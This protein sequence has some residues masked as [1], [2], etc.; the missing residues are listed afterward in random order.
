MGWGGN[1]LSTGGLPGWFSNGG[2]FK[3]I[4]H[5]F[6]TCF[7]YALVFVRARVH[8]VWKTKDNFQGLVLIFHNVGPEDH[9]AWWQAPFPSEL[10][11]SLAPGAVVLKKSNLT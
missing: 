10:A 8:P 4:L 1:A 6:F 5:L 7:V 9:Q 3:Y 2:F 11:S